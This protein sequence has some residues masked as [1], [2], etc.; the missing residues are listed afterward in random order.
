MSYVIG[1]NA[2]DENEYYLSQNAMLTNYFRLPRSDITA[3][4]W[5]I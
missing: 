4:I 2:N 3:L 1:F 5:F